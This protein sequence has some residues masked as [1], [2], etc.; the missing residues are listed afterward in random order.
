MQKTFLAIKPDGVQRGFI[1][2]IILRLEEKGFKLI[3]MKLMKVSNELAKKHYAEHKDKPFFK[4]L[5]D[6]IMSGPIVA[7]VWE[8]KNIITSLRKIM[9]KTNPLDADLGTIRGDFAVDIGKNVVHG[10]DS[11]E[12]AKREIA[13]FF[14]EE[15]LITWEQDIQ[16]WIYE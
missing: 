10:S 16:K 4:G 12:S 5:V 2:K 7:M 11:E 6:F 9:G 15:E 3:G 13:L 14:K 1:G 8:G